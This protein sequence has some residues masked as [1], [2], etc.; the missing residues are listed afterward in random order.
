MLSSD[1]SNSIGITCAGAIMKMKQEEYA[2]GYVSI[3][4]PTNAI[5]S[6]KCCCFMSHIIFI[7]LMLYSKSMLWR[8]DIIL[9][10]MEDGWP[11]KIS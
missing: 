5:L 2:I 3:Y 1:N 4:A 11:F 9:N 10:N 6:P 8:L 7:F